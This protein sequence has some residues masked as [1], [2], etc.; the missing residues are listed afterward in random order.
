MAHGRIV[1]IA[2][3]AILVAAGMAAWTGCSREE[4]PLAPT[5]TGPGKDG[6]DLKSMEPTPQLEAGALSI[7]RNDGDAPPSGLVTVDNLT[8]WPY[9]GASFSGEP[10]D[11]INLLLCGQADPVRVRAALLALDGDRTAFG[12]PD[13]WPFNATWTDC[14]GGAVQTTYAAG[15][16]GWVGSVVQLMLGAYDPVRF[17]LRLFHT[18]VADGTGGEWTLG[19]A[20]F[21][22][23]IPGTADHQ[24]LSWEIAQ[25]IVVADLMRSGLLGGATPVLPSGTINA[26]PSFRA[27]PAVIYN[28]LPPELIALIGGPPP[29]VAADVPLSSD[30][31]AT[32]LNLTGQAPLVPGTWAQSVDLSYG[33]VVPKPFCSAG[34]EDYLL[35]AGPIT[36]NLTV[37]LSQRGEYSYHSDYLGELTA[38]PVDIT[39][40]QPVPAG[41]PYAARVTGHSAGSLRADWGQVWSVDKK[42][43]RPG[44]GP[45]LLYEWLQALDRGP[46]KYSALTRC[47]DDDLAL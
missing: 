18:G 8:F 12:L 23:R 19:G 2:A 38:T 26:A 44:A 29:P 31:E 20:H 40:G 34:P 43:T 35:V 27:I 4:D 9:T 39:S 45:E 41:D 6:W 7:V 10:V 17:H 5:V 13:A 21:E 16:D 22:V 1:S 42:L 11:P 14:I 28:G 24:V 3:A 46:K 15:P 37:T 30:G 47:V 36:F 32:I 33:Q 25:Q